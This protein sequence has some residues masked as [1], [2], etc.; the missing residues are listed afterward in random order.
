MRFL[1][2][3]LLLV[4]TLSLS[5]CVS[6]QKESL[7]P[8]NLEPSAMLRFTDLPVPAGFKILPEKSFILE[9]GGMR[10][11][12]LRYTGKADAQSA[13]LFYKNQM[14]IYNWA[15]LSV[16][17]YGQRM[18]NFER[19]NESCVITISQ[20]GSRVELIISLAPK[21][22]IPLSGKEKTEEAT[23]QPKRK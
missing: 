9:S 6:M 14:P 5:G 21:S 1:P 16:L 4:L 10:A 3:F 2:L 12:I 8:Q 13:V 17:E 7:E 20:V 19:E 22:P 18:L 15:L 23:K 11:G